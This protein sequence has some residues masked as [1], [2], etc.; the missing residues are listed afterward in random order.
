MRFPPMPITDSGSVCY[1][2]RLLGDR[3]VDRLPDPPGGVGAELE[4]APR[5]ELPNRP[6][7]PHVA[8]LDQV[9]EVN[10]APEIALGHTDDQTQVGPAQGLRGL[11]AALLGG[12]QLALQF[13]VC[14]Q[15]A[16]KSALVGKGM[17]LVDKFQKPGGII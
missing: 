17:V 2:A 5:V 16:E 10:A 13:I 14:G 4:A 8:L 1:G 12:I 3:A 6:Q 15:V 9:K 7:Q 11:H